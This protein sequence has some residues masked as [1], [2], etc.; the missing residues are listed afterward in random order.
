MPSRVRTAFVF[1]V[2]AFAAA[3]GASPALATQDAPDVKAV[4]QNRLAVSQAKLER[5]IE[6][7]IRL[8]LG[9]QPLPAE[10]AALIGLHGFRD[11][12]DAEKALASE[13][14]RLA[15]ARQRLS[16]L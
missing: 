10:L 1:A 12:K 11:P 8:D 16:D 13:E 3:L 15:A 5:L 7:R 2:F 9:I 6:L 4:L 14:Q